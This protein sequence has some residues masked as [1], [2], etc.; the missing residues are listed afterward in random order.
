MLEG[1]SAGN[2]PSTRLAFACT[3]KDGDNTTVQP[4]FGLFIGSADDIVFNRGVTDGVITGKA[5]EVSVLS[6]AT[7]DKLLVVGVG[8]RS[9]LTPQGLRMAAGTACGWM[10]VHPKVSNQVAIYLYGDHPFAHCARL[11]MEGWELRNQTVQRSPKLAAKETKISAVPIF[12]GGQDDIT[13]EESDLGALT[14]HFAHWVR[15]VGNLRGSEGTPLVLAT[16]AY[17]FLGDLSGVTTT[18]L[19]PDFYEGRHT[20]NN[21]RFG[22]F[23]SVANGAK[24][25]PHGILAVHRCG[26]KGA[27]ILKIIG[28]GVTYDTGGFNRK[29]DIAMNDM[30]MDMMGMANATALFKLLVLL[31][32]QYCDIILM[33]NCTENYDGTLPSDIVTTRGEEG[34][35]INHSDAEGR[36]VLGDG[37]DYG[38][39][40]FHPN[41]ILDLATLTGAAAAALGGRTALFST[42]GESSELSGLEHLLPLVRAVDPSGFTMWP[43]PMPWNQAELIGSP[44]CDG[45]NTDNSK[46]YGCGTAALYLAQR[47]ANANRLYQGNT[48]LIHADIAGAARR[49]GKPKGWQVAGASPDAFLG[50]AWGLPGLIKNGRLFRR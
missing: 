48:V 19:D 20:L 23:L 49:V 40:T 25:P 38:V 35:E 43:M 37:I 9:K 44:E 39:E 41:V 31:V 21:R 6:T 50:L 42:A 46:V 15:D 18:V 30:Y 7:G 45:V 27:K 2:L 4:L 3:G 16:R 11:I 22:A 33:A 47:L 26:K 5:D 36:L 14:A 32:G 10:R 13:R 12:V 8:D 28:K 24:N 17:D 29:P 34:V 1:S